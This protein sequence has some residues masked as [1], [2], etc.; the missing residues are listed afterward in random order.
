MSLVG[1]LDQGR[2]TMDGQ[3]SPASNDIPNVDASAAAETHLYLNFVGT[4]GRPT[5][6]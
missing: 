6:S 5:A 2:C 3:L 1:E 4:C